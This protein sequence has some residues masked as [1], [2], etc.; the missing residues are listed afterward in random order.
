M[1]CNTN[2]SR[3]SP[4]QERLCEMATI[5]TPNLQMIS[6]RLRAT[7]SG[8]LRL[9]KG[10]DRISVTVSLTPKSFAYTTFSYLFLYLQL[11]PIYLMFQ[12]GMSINWVCIKGQVVTSSADAF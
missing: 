5:I 7:Y 1:L 2:L 4:L 6:L 8:L 3:T 12:H 11:I 10:R 9:V